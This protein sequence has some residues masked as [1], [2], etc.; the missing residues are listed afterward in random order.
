[1]KNFLLYLIAAF[2]FLI[3]VWSI[4]TTLEVPGGAKIRDTCARHGGISS[5]TLS[6]PVLGS[7]FIVCRDGYGEYSR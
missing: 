4:A 3:V 1:M 5:V 2:L 6:A 7:T